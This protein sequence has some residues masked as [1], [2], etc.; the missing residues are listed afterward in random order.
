MKTETTT[1]RILT[2]GNRQIPYRIIRKQRKY[3]RIL[4]EPNLQVTIYAPTNAEDCKIN[5]FLHKKAFWIMQK[6][7]YVKTFHPLPPPRE[8]I[9]GETFRFLGRQYRLKIEQGN[10]SPAKLRGRFLYVMISDKHDYAKAKELVTAWYRL[11]AE[12]T[13]HRITRKCSEITSRHEVPAASI[14]LRKMRTRW[15][16]CNSKNIITI[17]TNLIQAPIHCIEY[18]I[19]HELCHL[20]HHNHSKSFY[21]L[22]SI[23]MPDWKIRKEL[24]QKVVIPE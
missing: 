16:S 2:F 7:D 6:L 18:V 19:M 24:L 13:F 20:K 14:R 22:L 1:K 12:H 11:Q 5:E 21:K 15:G 23:C 8:Y 4:V 3:L 17:N 9:N 10:H